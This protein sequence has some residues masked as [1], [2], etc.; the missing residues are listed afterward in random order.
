MS[1]CE[2]LAYTATFDGVAIDLASSPMGYDSD[3][4]TFS[5]YSTDVALIGMQDF[6]IEAHLVDYDSITSSTE[7][8]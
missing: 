6:T 2:D 5:I 7:T 8:A 1:I 4:R 3:T